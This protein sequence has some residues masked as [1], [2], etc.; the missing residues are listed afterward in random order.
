MKSQV[1]AVKDTPIR[2][3][4]LKRAFEE[5]W[6]LEQVNSELEK[7]FCERLYARNRYEAGLIY[8]F[9]NRISYEAWKELYQKYIEQG[10]NME[11]REDG[12]KK[13]RI[14]ESKKQRASTYTS[15]IWRGEDITFKAIKDYV[16]KNSQNEVLETGMR[17]FLVEEELKHVE[18]V[19]YNAGF[20]KFMEK[21]ESEFS[22]VREKAR[23]YF[24]KY[25]SFYIEERCQRY[26][27]KCK[28]KEVAIS[29]GKTKQELEPYKRAEQIAFAEL[30]VLKNLS[31]LK[32]ESE[33]IKINIPLVEKMNYVDNA[34][35]SYRTLFDRFNYFY[36][37]FITLER[38]E[39][40]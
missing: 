19:E 29:C 22:A 39:Y 2:I 26:Y 33:K 16:R 15:G 17:T 12:I 25:L 24:C 20:R 9:Q 23:Y 4:I 35:L 30:D 1:N 3:K 37:G 32:A 34:R 7:H 6:N 36:F 14:F 31:V 21:N 38:A 27:E 13:K 18:T 5:G 28:E 40:L 8:A 10:R 11:N